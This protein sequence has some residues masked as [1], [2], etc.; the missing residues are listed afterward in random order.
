LLIYPRRSVFGVR[1]DH[2]LVAPPL[3]IDHAGVDE[4]I[5]RLDRTLA[6]LQIR[7][8]RH[9]YEVDATFDDQTVQRYAQ[10]VMVPAYARG[11]IGATGP[12]KD[13]NVTAAMETGHFNTQDPELGTDDGKESA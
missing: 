7:L 11:D 13:A 8:E 9:I 12:A 5:G 10:P 4:L 2:V 3:I 6:D 1:G